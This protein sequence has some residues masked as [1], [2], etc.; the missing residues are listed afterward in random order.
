MGSTDK[1]IRALKYYRVYESLCG[2]SSVIESLGFG[3]LVIE[4]SMNFDQPLNARL[5]EELGA[6]L[7]VIK[8]EKLGLEISE[9]SRVIQEVGVEESDQVRHILQGRW[10]GN[11]RT[12]DFQGLISRTIWAGNKNCLISPDYILEPYSILLFP[13]YG[14]EIKIATTVSFQAN[15]ILPPKFSLIWQYYH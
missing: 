2:W 11:F 14:Q 5:V 8:G 10:A 1:S 7:K 9:V 12:L 4:I 15:Y 13:D 3:F 6:E